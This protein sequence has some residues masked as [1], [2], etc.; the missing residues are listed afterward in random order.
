MGQ[1]HQRLSTR[2]ILLPGGMPEV[3]SG[4]TELPRETEPGARP[5]GPLGNIEL[6]QK[7]SLVQSQWW[8]VAVP[9]CTIFRR[10]R[11]ASSFS[12]PRP[13][14]STPASRAWRLI[15]YGT[16]RPPHSVS[17]WISYMMS[18]A[19]TFFF[20]PSSNAYTPHIIGWR[21]W[22]SAVELAALLDFSWGGPGAYGT[23]AA[24]AG[25]AT[26]TNSLKNLK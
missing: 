5:V 4:N 16:R 18:G 21:G 17:P 25:G 12:S 2:R 20:S 8:T 23:G 6:P 15:L 26:L 13:S 7:T 19:E 3:D 14:S 11:F 10:L 1:S 24:V 9:R 22:K